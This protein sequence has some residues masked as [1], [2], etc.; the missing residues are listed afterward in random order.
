MAPPSFQATLNSIVA[1]SINAL[2]PEIYITPPSCALHLKN[3]LFII[4]VSLPTT[5][6]EPP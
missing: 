6:I 2:A 4:L 1:L 5:S 3:V